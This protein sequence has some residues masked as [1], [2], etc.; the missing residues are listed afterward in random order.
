MSLS[1]ESLQNSD[2]Q[3]KDLPYEQFSKVVSDEDINKAKA[4]LEAAGHVA[5]VVSTREEALEYIKKTIPKDASVMNAGS[6]TLGE[7]G[8]NDY[9]K[10]QTEWKNL[11]A[12]ILAEADHAKQAE[13][14]RLSSTADWFLS[15]VTAVSHQ[16]D[17]TVV[18]LTGSR[19]GPFAFSAGHVL[20]VVGANKIVPTYEDAVKRTEQY[21]LPLESARVRIAYAAMGVKASKINNFLAIRGSNPWGVPGRIQVVIVKEALGF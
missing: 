3:L 10:T 13:L 20:I 2:P 11:H 21:C 17:I 19:V 8:L 1:A 18:D 15:S 4:G 9:L 5:V 7:I 12:E 6:T 14:R 16:G